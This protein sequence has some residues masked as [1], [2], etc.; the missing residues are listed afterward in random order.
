MNRLIYINGMGPN[1]KGDNIYEFIFSDTLEVWGE[2]WESKPA[3]GYPSPPDIEYIK[4]VGT[5]VNEDV[6]L[7]LV[8]DSDVFSVIDSMDGVLALGWE[9]EN[10]TVDFSLVKRLVFQFGDTEDIVKDKLYE[11]DIVLEFEKQVVYEK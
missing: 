4:K 2:N 1:Y 10:D 3:N 9:K 7:E 11:R 6:N 8:Q 5:L